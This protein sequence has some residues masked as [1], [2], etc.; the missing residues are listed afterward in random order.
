MAI[1]ELYISG[2][3]SIRN[4]R[5]PVEHLTVFVGPNGCGKSNLYRSMVLLAA[6]AEGRFA[7]TLAAEGGMPSALWAGE[8]RKGS[9]RMALGVTC[10]DWE[11]LLETGLPTCTDAAF[12]LDPMVKQ[13]RVG[14]AAAAGRKTV[15]ME[16]KGPTAW[17]RDRDGKQAPYE[18]ALL[19]TE[20]ALAQ[21]RDP[22]AFPEL[23]A[24]RGELL[25]WRLYDHFRT[26]P[27]SPIRQPQVGVVTPSLSADGHDLA[28][29]LQTV[30]EI[31]DGH[32]L[33]RAV[34]DA[35][36]GARLEISEQRGRYEVGMRMP[37]IQRPFEARE[38]SDG[39]LRYLCLLGAL[40]SHCPPEFIVL[41]E[42]ETSLHGDLLEP[43]AGLIARASE[44]AQIWVI[45]HSEALAAQ[46]EAHAGC[47]PRRMAKVAGETRI[48]GLMMSG[49]FSDDE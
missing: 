11:Y 5:L 2:Y 48:E 33:H 43:L 38:L 7:L 13:E 4:L 26:D 34:D 17:L 28:A 37:D 15:M 19:N 32:D 44:R 41:N 46:I 39:T 47:R 8:R 49:E 10:D 20:C 30:I 42:P 27:D 18:Y 12:P 35:F 23:A 36:P 25:G 24:L 31:G 14:R 1:R 9:V 21:I 3:R 6:A 16:R 29:T 22:V 40:M 45:T